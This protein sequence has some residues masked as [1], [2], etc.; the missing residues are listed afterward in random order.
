MQRLR[1]IIILIFIISGCNLTSNTQDTLS[2]T[3]PPTRTLPFA[4]DVNVTENAIVLDT[5]SDSSTPPPD[6][7]SD[8]TPPA[9]ILCVPQ[10]D[11][12]QYT[13]QRRDNLTNIASR[14][15]STVDELIAANCLDN[16][17]RI[18]VGDTIYVPNE[19]E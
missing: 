11:W 15:R 8:E 14:T 18:R 1:F 16:P 4:T 19:P 12:Y 7:A 13:I 3:P 6:S 2:D 10:R 9:G 17:N 5:P